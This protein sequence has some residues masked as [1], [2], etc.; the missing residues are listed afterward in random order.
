MVGVG[1][2]VVVVVV[3][4]VGVAVGV[5][6][7]VGV[8]VVVV[9]AVGV[10]VVVGV[11]MKTDLETLLELATRHVLGETH[12]RVHKPLLKEL[13]ERVN[14]AEAKCTALTAQIAELKANQLTLGAVERC[15]RCNVNIERG[16]CLYESRFGNW[17]HPEADQCPVFRTASQDAAPPPTEE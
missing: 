1:V 6:V 8:G 14:A 9:V 5:V 13:I 16:C 3:V 12:V 2:G 11:A 4:G 10:A 7:G 15:V 17:R